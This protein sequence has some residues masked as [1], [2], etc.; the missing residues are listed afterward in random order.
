MAG[1]RTLLGR[2]AERFGRS[3]RGRRPA[4]AAV[5]ERDG[6]GERSA[7]ESRP[8]RAARCGGPRV[9]E[10]RRERPAQPR[11]RRGSGLRRGKHFAA[12]AGIGPWTTEYI[13]MRALGDP[14]AFLTET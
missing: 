11:S 13:A 10:R 9:V 5:S 4:V 3:D 14:D 8:H 2:M 12:I 7:R 1:A 6:V